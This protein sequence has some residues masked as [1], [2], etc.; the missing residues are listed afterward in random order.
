M[1]VAGGREADRAVRLDV[2]VLATML[3]AGGRE[4]D[5]AVGLDVLWLWLILLTWFVRHYSSFRNFAVDPQD[6]V[7]ALNLPCFASKTQSTL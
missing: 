5:R 2:F 1:L 6:V 4:A 3:V 7:S